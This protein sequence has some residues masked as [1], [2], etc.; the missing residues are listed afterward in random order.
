M[1]LTSLASP[2]AHAPAYRTSSPLPLSWVTVAVAAVVIAYGDGFIVTALHGAVGSVDT[3][4][5]PFV[6]WLRDSTLMVAPLVL[7][8]MAALVLARRFVGQ[9]RREIVQL[10]GAA[11]LM[12]IISSAASIAEVSMSAVTEYKT[13]SAELAVIH[14]NHATTP[15]V[16]PGA[17]VVP[18]QSCTG[19][20]AAKHLTLMV[21]LRAAVYASV[22]LLITNIALVLWILA[23]RGGRLW[24]S[25]ERR[26]ANARAR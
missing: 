3:S 6:R 5:E 21:Q 10:A 7:A 13:Q 26:V 14:A 24:G 9:N 22:I 25:P 4:Q 18:T 17:S 1:S 2:E 16:D 12:I 23:M 8:V 11:L 19:L 20:C 15:V